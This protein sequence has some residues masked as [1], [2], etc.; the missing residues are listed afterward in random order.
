MSHDLTVAID[1][2][3]VHDRSG[4]VARYLDGIIGL[5]GRSGVATHVVTRRD[6]S[7]RW[8]G[9]LGAHA[10]A[11]SARP[12]RLVWEQMQLLSR[13]GELRPAVEVLHSPHYT[14]PL[15]GP[16]LGRVARVVTI[17]DLTF[18][19]HPE[20]HSRA[21]RELFTRAIRLAS[22]HA[23]ALICVSNT[24]ADQLGEFT[25]ARAPIHVIPHGVDHVRFTASTSLDDRDH[26]RAY[27]LSRPYV[28]S[29]GAIEPRKNVAR[30]AL[31]CEL[32]WAEQ[33]EME[34]VLVGQPWRGHTVP[35]GRNG[36]IRHLGFVD[37]AAR[38]AL[39]RGARVVAYPSLAEGFGLPVLEA[40][41]C[42]AAVV[43]SAAGATGEVAGEAAILVDPLDVESIASGLVTG[44]AGHG[45]D[46]AA[47]VARAAQF[48][49][50]RS[51]AAH[52][53][54]YRSVART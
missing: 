51:A 10:L 47:R 27:G 13:L 22:R 29:I 45:P 12:A 15:R 24:T 48:T 50:E 7:G 5:L 42:G 49:W 31:A 4:G 6:G 19:T 54:V 38:P 18:F 32:L 23:D 53:G 52:A 40:L 41:A 35:V 25:P 14:M 2:S 21:K 26:L 3:A 37:D 11:P 20:T 8:L 44:L 46:T 30:L 34:L 33:A 1:A 36:T 39:I 17:H 9:S 43:T 28:L 16:G